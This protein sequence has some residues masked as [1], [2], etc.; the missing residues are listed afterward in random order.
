MR[1][2]SNRVVPSG[3]VSGHYLMAKPIEHYYVRRRSGACGHSHHAP[4]KNL[5]KCWRGD[6][7]LY[8]VSPEGRASPV[9]HATADHVRALIPRET[10]GR[11]PT[12]A[13]PRTRVQLRVSLE[14]RAAYERA[15]DA[16]GLSV[17]EWAKRLL[18]HAQAQAVR[19]H[20]LAPEGP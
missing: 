2:V 15:A 18:D 16:A 6:G 7:R 20:K 13:P 8:Y 3:G 11:P 5:A 10:R 9:D 4:D 17:E 12:G 19:P 1:W 14:E